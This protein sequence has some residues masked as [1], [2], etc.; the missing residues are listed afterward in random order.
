MATVASKVPFYDVTR[1]LEKID[2]KSGTEA[3]KE[4]LR[5]F[6][7]EWRKLHQKLY[8]DKPT[9]EHFNIV[10]GVFAHRQ[11]TDKVCSTNDDEH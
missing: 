2:K 1:L 11:A 7:E 9:V 4:V 3:K 10:N 8:G 6:I 5:G